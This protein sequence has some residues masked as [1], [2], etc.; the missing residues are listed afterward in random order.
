MGRPRPRL[1]LWIERCCDA[2]FDL[3]YE[4]WWG[5]ALHPWVLIALA[6]M[7]VKLHVVWWFWWAVA[8]WILIF[9]FL[10]MVRRREQEVIRRVEETICVE[11]GYDLRASLE[12]CPECGTPVPMRNLRRA[13]LW[14]PGRLNDKHPNTINGWNAEKSGRCDERRSG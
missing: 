14:P 9:V 13:G 7:M 8:G 4:R 3:V 12:C 5:G 1:T 2:Y 10:L 11:C 6:A